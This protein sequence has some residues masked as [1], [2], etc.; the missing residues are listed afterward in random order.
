M[1]Q[2]LFT[3]GK[4]AKYGGLF[5]SVYEEY[6]KAN[7]PFT[8]LEV[9]NIYKD[10]KFYPQIVS[11][12]DLAVRKSFKFPDPSEEFSEADI[13]YKRWFVYVNAK[14]IHDRLIREGESGRPALNQ[15]EYVCPL[16]RRIQELVK[17]GTEIDMTEF[18]SPYGNYIETF[19]EL[20]KDDYRGNC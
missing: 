5:Y 18:N 6:I 2:D 7:I 13:S 16:E 1:D 12:V 3:F 9:L 20:N 4:L 14:F 19:R 17:E 8:T 15:I 10:D 11:E